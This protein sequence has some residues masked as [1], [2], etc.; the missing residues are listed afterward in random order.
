M[1]HY[2]TWI[3]LDVLHKAKMLIGMLMDKLETQVANGKD[4]T[5]AC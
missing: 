2:S 4:T 3:Q 5:K 1:N